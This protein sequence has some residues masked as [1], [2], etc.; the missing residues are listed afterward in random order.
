MT[1]K[2][3]AKEIISG[4][5]VTNQYAEQLRSLIEEHIK[6]AVLEERLRCSAI[7]RRVAACGGPSNADLLD[8]AEEMEDAMYPVLSSKAMR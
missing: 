3:R 2:E 7:C 8:C 1:P 5:N 4:S 6:K